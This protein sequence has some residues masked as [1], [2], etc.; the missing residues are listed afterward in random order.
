MYIQDICVCITC[1]YVYMYVY[2]YVCVC[3]YIYIYI[4]Y[5][6][7]GY[8]QDA[9]NHCEGSALGLRFEVRVYDECVSVCVCVCAR[10]DV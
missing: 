8:I 4:M 9:R 7:T 2:M 5:V 10:G 3:V 6:Y 1:M